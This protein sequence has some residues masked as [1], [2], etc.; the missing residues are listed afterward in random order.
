[1]TIYTFLIIIH[2]IGTVLG[3]GGATFAEIFFLKSAKDGTFD[4]EESAFLHITYAVLRFGMVLLILSG[5]GFLLLYRFTDQTE[6]LYN[7]KLW[8]KL[9]IIFMLL[10]NV[11]AMQSRRIPFWL[12]S[13]LSLTSWYAALTL[14]AWRGLDAPYLAIMAGYIAAVACIAVILICVRRVLGIKL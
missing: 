11:L 13:S 10:M 9:S 6:L 7:P 12:G 14:G 3:A 1:M 8:A 4:Q 2:I 5:F